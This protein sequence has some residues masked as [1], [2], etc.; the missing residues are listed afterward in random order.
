MIVKALLV[1]SVTSFNLA[2]VPRCPWTNCLMGNMQFGA[3]AVE[4][5]NP[6]CFSRICKLT[7]IVGLYDFR[8]ISEIFNSPFYKIN[9]AVT[10]Y[11]F[12]GIDKSFPCGFINH[13]ILIKTVL[14]FADIAGF[15]DVL[16]RNFR[17]RKLPLIRIYVL[18]RASF[19]RDEGHKTRVRKIYLSNFYVHLALLA[20]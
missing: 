1:I 12:V 11:F 20:R 3:K 4:G 14:I 6:L 13:G 17:S 2:V 9:S 7:S 19:L 18:H 10:A 15:G 5:M 16:I 8:D